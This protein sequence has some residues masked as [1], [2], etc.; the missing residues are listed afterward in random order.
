MSLL[1][2]LLLKLG[3]FALTMGVVFWIVWQAPQTM[4][5]PIPPQPAS[6][7]QAGGLAPSLSVGDA[8]GQNPVPAN[9][10]Q[11]VS[12]D[13][14]LIDLN[15]A[16]VADFEQLPGVGPVL[17]RRVIAYR[18]SR[19]RFH[20]VEDLRGVKGIGQKKLERLRRLVTVTPPVASD[21]GEKASI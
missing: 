3:M 17:A 5:R 2:S 1:R 19:G 11:S 15:R 16:S 10:P 14:K 8:L 20:A 13:P 4:Q 6:F 18:E 7:A 9:S 21:K 12:K